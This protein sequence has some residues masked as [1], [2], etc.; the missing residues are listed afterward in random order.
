MSCIQIIILSV[1]MVNISHCIVYVHVG[2]LN[3]E[4]RGGVCVLLDCVEVP[5]TTCS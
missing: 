5:T 1:Y 4:S 3:F 2:N